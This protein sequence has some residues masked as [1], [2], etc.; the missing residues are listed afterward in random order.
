MLTP[1]QIDLIDEKSASLQSLIQE[2]ISNYNELVAQ[3]HTSLTSKNVEGAKA[4][5]KAADGVQSERDYYGALRNGLLSVKA[6][7]A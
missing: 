6:L 4:F 7:L 2:K 1:E 3:A 5:L